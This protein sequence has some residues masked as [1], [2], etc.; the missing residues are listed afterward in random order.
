MASEHSSA[1]VH[2]APVLPP[3]GPR[4]WE[5][6]LLAA[7]LRSGTVTLLHGGSALDR[8]QLLRHGVLP[9]LA[10][11]SDDLAP[12]AA[13]ARVLKFPDRRDAVTGASATS[14]AEGVL[15]IGPQ[16]REPAHTL[17][18]QFEADAA[19]PAALPGRR[20]LLLL[21]DFD[22]WLAPPVDTEPGLA[23][24]ARAF[25]QALAQRMALPGTTLH[26]L[27]ATADP[28]APALLAL[29]GHWPGFGDQVLRLGIGGA[30]AGPRL[31]VLPSASGMPAAPEQGLEPQGA[32]AAAD[33]EAADAAATAQPPR[34]WLFAPATASLR[35]VVPPTASAVAAGVAEPQV[36]TAPAPEECPPP[37]FL[38]LLKAT[39]AA[40]APAVPARP[41][42][43]APRRWH[44][45][46][47]AAAIALL[48]LG[49]AGL[50]S[51]PQSP[52]AP[53]PAAAGPTR[54]LAQTA[55]AAGPAPRSAATVEPGQALLR[56]WAG[57][58]LRD[59]RAVADPAAVLG[60]ATR[61]PGLLLLRYDSLD[62]LRRDAANAPRLQLVAPLFIEPVTA[63]VRADTALRHWHELRGRSVAAL[64]SAGATAG[65]VLDTAFGSAEAPRRQALDDAAAWTAL[66]RGEVDAVLR[67]GM[68]AGSESGLRA[69]TLADDPPANDALLRGLLR[70]YLRSTPAPLAGGATPGV[71]TFLAATG[72]DPAAVAA[73]ALASVEALCS[74]LPALRAADP[75]WAAV[76]PDAR[77]PAPWPY[78]PAALAASARAD[79]CQRP[80]P[81]AGTA[82]AQFPHRP[83]T[84]AVP[85]KL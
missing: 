58:P 36:P 35:A 74:A 57:P 32:E 67:V 34:G 63:W 15:L 66:A 53:G 76:R 13:R 79:G 25:Q 46:L 7:S 65:Q 83:G 10:R 73:L 56:L 17:A 85:A 19:A 9:L 24:T 64:P 5:A 45:A 23:A 54:P 69:L 42:R 47:S 41:D 39:P 43:V 2:P 55:E 75:V 84:A 68:P 8:S 61:E 33:D 30:G 12:I 16:H 60:A 37:P 29:A 59:L 78:V 70:R 52:V 77:L 38:E 18:R 40:P 51:L 20:L 44:P 72:N 82:A 6:R 81:A 49:G 22:L 31:G 48:A 14:P 11:R 71:M 50:L 80:T 4:S 21:D 1:I 28:A 3:W 27:I 62:A 26:V